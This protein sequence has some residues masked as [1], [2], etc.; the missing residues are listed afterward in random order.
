L[1]KSGLELIQSFI[2][3]AE[4]LNFRRSAERMNIDQSALSR[5]IQKLEHLLDF[6]LFERTT[7][8]V[9]LTPA[10]RAFYDENSRIFQ[11]YSKSIE[12]ARL[13]SEGKTGKLHVAHTAFTATILMPQTVALY[14]QKYPFVGV[15]LSNIRTQGQ[16]LALAKD[17]IDLG[18][19]VGPFEHSEFHSVVLKSDPL[20]VMM[21]PGHPLG[22]KSEI[23]PVDLKGIDIILGNMFEW[24]TY[25]RRLDDLFNSSGVSLKIALE[26]SNT[27]ATV[28]L[29]AAGTG[30]SILP[31]S[32]AGFFG[33][34]VEMRPISNPDFL[35]QHILVWRNSNR[36]KILRNFVEVAKS[37]CPR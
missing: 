17:E 29:V 33:S 16:K 34:G 9:S 23:R 25:R 8:D 31:K 36:T 15:H 37:I 13:V 14:Q 4:E 30:V 27:I 10:G 19:M 3:V 28:G 7:R 2:I 24:E 21:P 22:S 5:C 35:V 20:W 32:F 1:S 6:P 18:Y 12:T 11:N 26:T